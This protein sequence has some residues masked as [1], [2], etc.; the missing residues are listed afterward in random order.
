MFDF[1]KA[2]QE[3]IDTLDR[4]VSVSAGAGSGKT[5][6][7]VE[8]FVNILRQSLR[9]GGK[10]VSASD[11]LAITFTRKAA[12]EM[13]ER[14]R[15]RLAE[16]EQEDA[17]HAAFWRQQ[18]ALL[19]QARINTI[20]GFCNS[21]LKENPVEAGLDP[22]FQVAEEV[23]M[24]EFLLRT[25]QQFV[26]QGL[27][28]GDSNILR[29]ADEY[30]AAAVVK[31]LLLVAAKLDSIAAFGDLTQPYQ[32]KLTEEG[33]LQ[34]Q[35]QYLL[36]E[37]ATGRESVKA[38]AQRQKL[39]L[40][41]AQLPELLQAAAN[42]SL[43][44]NMELLELYVGGLLANSSDKA[45]VKEAKV[46]LQQLQLL[47]ADRAALELLPC[48]QQILINCGVY[49]REQQ[50][51][52]N[53]LGFDDLESRAL[54]L[55][56]NNRQI[57]G[58]NSKRYQYIMVDEFQDTN[59][60]QREL[61]YLLC[62]GDKDLLLGNKLF[63][64][65]DAKQSIYRFRGADVSVFARVRSD[66]KAAGGSNI[67]LDDNFR[68]VDKVLDLC[69]LAFAALLGEDRKQDVYFEALNANRATE[70]LPEMLAIAY[71]KES[72]A[73]RREAEAAVIARRMLELHTEEQLD[74]ADMVIL[75]SA[76]T[77]AKTF[78]A[79]LQQA[80]IPYNIVDGK[81]FYERREIIDLINLLIFLDDSSRSLELAGV[82][83]SPYFAVDDE[84]LTAFFLEL[85]RQESET[86]TLWQLLQQGEWPPLDSAVRQS[87]QAAVRVL[88]Q[89]R[90]CAAVMPL[91]E[92]LHT[93]VAVLQLEPLLAAQEFGMEKLANVKK[94]I[95]LAESY[96]IEKHGTLADYLL[97]LQQLR[98]AGAREAAA[99]DTTGCASV[100]IMTIHK[101]KGLEFPVVFVPALDAKGKSDTDML[102]FNSAA[103]LGIKVDVGGELQDT[104]VM[105]Q[106]KE[107]EKQ[108]DASEKQRQLYVAMTRAQD[109]LILSG[110][111][112]GGSKSKSENWFSSLR[113]ILQDY[114]QFL[115]KEYEAGEIA[116]AVSTTAVPETVRLTGELLRRIRP[117]PE[118]G[119]A[120]QRVLSATALQTYLD[121]PRSYYY[122]HV[123][124]MPE[125]EVVSI[126]GDGYGLT[127]K[128]Q[129]TVIHKALELLVNGYE[130]EQ[131][132]TT[133]LQTYKAEKSAVR[134]Y[135][136]YRYYLNGPLYQKLQQ[137]ERKAEISF[138]LP[139]LQ[140]YGLATVFSGYID[141]TVFNNDGTL[142]IIDYKTGVPPEAEEPQPGYIYQ[143]ALYQKAAAELWQRPVAVAE[144]HFLQNNSCW[145]LAGR[146][147][148]LREV[149]DLC[150]DIFSK[151][152][153][154]EFTV[155]TEYCKN[156]PFAYFCTGTEETAK[157]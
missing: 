153:E 127:A 11:I 28:R 139:L 55:L 125:A 41:S 136:V 149:A 30:T 107:I 78:A 80:G 33:A 126:D 117:L 42:S 43:P 154:S 65:G 112:D 10:Q 96:T 111:Y 44:A 6:V 87:M 115:L 108:L 76:L 124:Q 103:G 98:Q 24:D 152:T 106:I 97:R 38:A 99:A 142:T 21:L 49:L 123:L 157:N 18:L 141:C 84:T 45:V 72:K 88:Q 17:L 51:L 4:N 130:P 16:L 8:R 89:L 105:L 53:M 15:Q 155:K 14:V 135:E 156:C 91:P 36:Q 58:K 144:L 95:A 113:N 92:L 150:K 60:R 77:S 22:A 90:Q 56:K 121:C 68:T 19:E 133:A 75:L 128:M 131:A 82:L 79:A 140:E 40:L 32:A 118:Y 67:I 119:L 37:L 109:R 26:K 9:P 101:S 122:K 147:D 145:K 50:E 47:A 74:Y 62:G 29:L 69:N 20:H 25:V 7:L 64:V 2:Q 129:G 134:A 70:L 31:Q 63:V 54:E 34:K 151:R 35:L 66:I 46:V 102:R 114:D 100:T 59:E 3:A 132:F 116:A 57:C 104:S 148:V 5:R 94:M 23:E 146:S 85:N 120:W 52:K 27:R 12:G 143:L 39:E 81:G 138:A 1:T 71:S 13:K 137:A 48:W 61:V 73:C 93:L 86:Y 110:T 83:R